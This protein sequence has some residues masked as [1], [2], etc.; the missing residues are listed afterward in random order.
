MARRGV[1]LGVRATRVMAHGAERLGRRV[2]GR[3]RSHAG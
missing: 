3:L 1:R 2:L